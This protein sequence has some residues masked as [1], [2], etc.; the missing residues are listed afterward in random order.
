MGRGEPVAGRRGARCAG[1]QWSGAQRGGSVP[2]GAGR[3]D[4]DGGG[5]AWMG[6][7]RSWNGRV[8]RA[9]ECAD[10][11]GEVGD[12]FICILTFQR[13]FALFDPKRPDRKSGR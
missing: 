3:R 10:K 9:D 8:K 11:H 6:R 12:F 13:E 5:D 2:A 1:G 7:V 4:G